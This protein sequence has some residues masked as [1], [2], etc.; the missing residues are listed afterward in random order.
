MN[1]TTQIDDITSVIFRKFQ[2][3]DVIAIFPDIIHNDNFHL[4][5]QHIGQHGGCDMK[6]CINITEPATYEEY[7]DL[8]TELERAGYKL[9]IIKNH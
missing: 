5:Y 9:R 7:K 1:K 6:G 4:S 8:K 2:E 3:G